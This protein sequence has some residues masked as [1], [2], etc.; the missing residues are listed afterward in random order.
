MERAILV[1]HVSAAEGEE[2][3]DDG[4]QGN[5]TEYDGGAHG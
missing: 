4:D 2:A 5:E 1:P 3:R